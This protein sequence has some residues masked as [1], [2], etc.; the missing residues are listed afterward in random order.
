MGEPV[1]QQNFI[2]KNRQDRLGLQAVVCQPWSQGAGFQILK[3]FLFVLKVDY[4]GAPAWLSR[5]SVQLWLKSWSHSSWVWALRWALCWQLGVWSLLWFLCLPLSAS[6]PLALCL[7]K[8]NKLKKKFFL[9]WLYDIHNLICIYISEF[10]KS[11]KRRYQAP[12][13]WNVTTQ[14]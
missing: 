14:R 13:S 8:A 5:W 6:P 3:F 9:R 12:S 1:F 11:W 10:L 7:S 4:M 2:Y